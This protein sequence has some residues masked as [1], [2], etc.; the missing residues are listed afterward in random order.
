MA[1]EI[2]QLVVRIRTADREG[3][4]TDGDVYVGI[5]GREFCIDSEE[6][7]FERKSVRVYGLAFPE[8]P[9]QTRVLNS[10][11][12]D[13]SQPYGLNIGNIEAHP[14]YI[15]FEPKDRNDNWILEYVLVRGMGYHGEIVCDYEGLGPE[16]EPASYLKFGTHSGKYLY[17]YKTGLIL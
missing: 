4:G 6:N 12:N 2:R 5:G 13:P 16:N 15:R 7:D 17:L 8:N 11:D 3:A 9:Q 14:V 10:N 1:G